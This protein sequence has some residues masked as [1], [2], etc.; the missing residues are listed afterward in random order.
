MWFTVV[1]ACPQ[2]LRKIQQTIQWRRLWPPSTYI[3]IQ[4]AGITAMRWR[5]LCFYLFSVSTFYL[6]Q[7]DFFWVVRLHS[8][9]SIS[10]LYLLWTTTAFLKTQIFL[11]L[12]DFGPRGMNFLLLVNL[13]PSCCRAHNPV[14][15]TSSRFISGVLQEGLRINLKISN[16]S[17]LR[18]QE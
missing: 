17:Y 6:W 2:L 3:P 8:L 5:A 7:K 4:T 9:S 12:N 10:G 16:L 15:K 14:R 1:V 11:E 18:A 13:S